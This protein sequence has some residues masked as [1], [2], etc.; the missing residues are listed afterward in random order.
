M[1]VNTF[2]HGVAENSISKIWQ[3]AE[4]CLH[5][6]CSTYCQADEPAKTSPCGIF[7]VLTDS[8]KYKFRPSWLLNGATAWQGV[9]Q[10]GAELFSFLKNQMFNIMQSV[11][12]TMFAANKASAIREKASVWLE[13]KCEF[14]S[15]LLG[16]KVS[17]LAFAGSQAGGALL[18]VAIVLCLD[19]I[20]EYGW[21]MCCLLLAA[22]CILPLVREFAK[23]GGAE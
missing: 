7:Y 3:C 9:E 2:F 12:E 5:L 8:H 11:Q 15:Q 20:A 21:A 22:H 6:Q 13:S 18:A 17:N 14:A 23:E 10:R 19:G 16:C 1:K 4:D